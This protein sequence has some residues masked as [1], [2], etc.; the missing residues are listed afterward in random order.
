MAA[1]DVA[2]LPL[3]VGQH[4]DAGVRR[5]ACPAGSRTRPATVIRA[6]LASFGGRWLA[7]ADGRAAG[8][9]FIRGSS[10]IT[11][12]RASQPAPAATTARSN[13][14]SAASLEL[15][16]QHGTEDLLG[17]WPRRGRRA[18]R[19][20]RAGPRRRSR[21]GWWNRT[22]GMRRTPGPTGAPARGHRGRREREAAAGQAA[23]ELLARPGQAAAERADGPSQPVRRLVEGQALEVAEHHRQAESP[24]QAIDLAVQGL[25]LLA[26][27]ER[28]LG[29]RGGTAPRPA[30]RTP[31]PR[32]VDG[33]RAGCGPC[34]PCAARRRRASCPAG[35]ARATTGPCGPGRGRRPGRR[36]RHG[37]GRRGAGGRRP[38]PSA[39]GGPPARRRRPHRGRPRTARA[40]AG[41]RARPPSR[42]RRATRAAGPAMSVPRLPYRK[43]PGAQ[44]ESMHGT[45]RCA[46]CARRPL[47]P[48]SLCCQ[49]GL[50]VI[51]GAPENPA[52][53]SQLASSKWDA[54]ARR[55]GRS[56]YRRGRA[57]R[58]A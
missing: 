45:I 19:R 43:P 38:A 50:H 40:V 53:I 34:G 26:V 4:R 27:E 55:L 25:G 2:D 18:P 6:G 57:S 42:P 14:D 54:S 31:L 48:S 20:R 33:G 29:R 44:V 5:S 16:E 51:P 7:A 36:P 47:I 24:R 9:L 35:R 22:G 58:P 3:A 10:P 32:S 12:G 46:R 1:V 23:P 28:P 11:S 8:G 37:G 15:V 17:Q 56:G 49:A 39:R 52:R 21:P 30:S 41:R 13:R